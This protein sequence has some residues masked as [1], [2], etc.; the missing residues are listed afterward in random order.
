M[1]PGEPISRTIRSRMPSPFSPLPIPC[2]PLADTAED[3]EKLVTREREEITLALW[4]FNCKE[5]ATSARTIVR[6]GACQ[7]FD[8]PC[9]PITD[10]IGLRRVCGKR[11]SLFLYTMRTWQMLPL[12]LHVSMFYRSYTSVPFVPVLTG[13]RTAYRGRSEAHTA[14]PV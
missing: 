8:A 13:L 11:L 12:L 10:R 4:P 14:V 3:A 1:L 2:R 5:A 7:P 6:A 9:E